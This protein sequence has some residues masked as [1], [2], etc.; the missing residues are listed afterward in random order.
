MHDCFKK[1]I[2]GGLSGI[3][4][5]MCVHPIDYIKTKR[6]IYIQNSIK[7]PFT[8]F[9]GNPY[10]GIVPRILGVAP[11][12]LVFWGVQKNTYDTL[13]ITKKY[14][15]YQC[16]IIAGIIGGSA[17]TI[18]DNPIENIKTRQMN[19]QIVQLKDIKNMPGFRSHL[20]RNIVFCLPITLL[21][22]NNES[23]SNINNFFMSSFSAFIGSILT[24]PLDYIKT[25]QQTGNKNTY[26]LIKNTFKKNPLIFFTG[27]ASRALAYSLSIG[28]GYVSY[29][30]IYAQL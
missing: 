18:I 12:R 30:N 5:V 24:Q 11:M 4:E 9:L 10:K 20:L 17:Q 23:K 2:A 14:T 26:E 27:G 1:Y 22:F 13:Q 28:I 7:S 19:N 29:T 16:S 25:Y 8:H 15:D 21:C 6:Q 3:I